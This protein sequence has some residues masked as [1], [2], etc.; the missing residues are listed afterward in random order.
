M[1]TLG[2]QKPTLRREHTLGHQAQGPSLC[3]HPL[4]KVGRAPG[5]APTPS[6]RWAGSPGGPVPS[7]SPGDKGWQGPSVDPAQGQP[8]L[9]LHVGQ[10]QLQHLV[11]GVCGPSA[12]ALEPLASLQD[13][14]Q[15]QQAQQHCLVW[16]QMGSVSSCSL[17]KT[18]DANPVATQG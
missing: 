16:G 7:V 6:G 13:G 18:T 8:M 10:H 15:V 14:Q 2:S 11:P 3:S 9:G 4:R 1:D 5:R 17:Q 12:L